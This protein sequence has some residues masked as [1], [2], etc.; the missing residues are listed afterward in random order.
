MSKITS[1]I[2]FLDESRLSFKI[3]NGMLCVLDQNEKVI[4]ERPL[5]IPIDADN[6]DVEE[7]YQKA[8]DCGYNIDDMISEIIQVSV[9]EN[10]EYDLWLSQDLVIFFSP[11]KKE[12]VSEPCEGVFGIIKDM[13]EE[14]MKEIEMGADEPETE[15]LDCPIED[16]DSTLVPKRDPN[17]EYG[18]E[19]EEDEE[20]DSEVSSMFEDLSSEEESFIDQIAAE[21]QEEP[22]IKGTI[23]DTEEEVVEELPEET[24]VEE[25][26]EPEVEEEPVV[27]EPTPAPVLEKTEKKVQPPVEKPVEKKPEQKNNVQKNKNDQPKVDV[28]KENKPEQPNKG[29]SQNQKQP[30][31][32]QK[33]QQ[34]NNNVAQKNEKEK[35]NNMSQTNNQNNSTKAFTWN[36]KAKTLRTAVD[37]LIKYKN[38]TKSN[39]IGDCAKSVVALI[40]EKH[41]DPNSADEKEILYTLAL[42]GKTIVKG[43]TPIRAGIYKSMLQKELRSLGF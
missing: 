12:W 42:N 43:L 11:T 31:N 2:K 7:I 30:Q 4:G 24:I 25:I 3:E 39:E 34:Q 32:Q 35:V 20:V 6:M 29:N 40:E 26:V 9:I 27:E 33:Q 18:D 15:N 22:E 37:E 28:K 36:D 19:D 38:E 41:I 14:E 1:K 8:E 10:K 16:N 17:F 21:E 23:E 13:Y 5:P